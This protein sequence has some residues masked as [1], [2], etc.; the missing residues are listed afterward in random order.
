MLDTLRAS[1][2]NASTM[3]FAYALARNGIYFERAIAPGTWTATSHAALF[4]GKKVTDI[5]EASEDF[6]TRG[7]YKIDPWMVKTKFLPADSNTL[8][9]RLSSR[10]E[11]SLFSNNPFV[12][13]FTNMGIGFNVV[14]DIWLHTNVKYNKKLTEKFSFV[15]NSGSSGRMAMYKASKFIASFMPRP[16]LDRVYMKLRLKLDEQVDRAD[17]THRLDRGI[18][19]TNKLL[20][21]YLSKYP[22]A[23]H[24]IFIN[25][26]EP[27]ENYPIGKNNINQDKWLYLSGILELDEKI[28]KKLHNGYV[29]RLR[30]LD[31][32]LR[33]SFAILKRL[34]F[35]EDAKVIITSDHGQSFGEH[36]QL[37]HAVFPYEEIAHVPFAIIDYSNGKPIASN[38]TIEEPANII[39]LYK[40]LVNNCSEDSIA[41]SMPT[42]TEHTSIAEGWDERLLL[43]LKDRSTIAR[44]IY[45]AKK[46]YNT[47][48]VAVYKGNYKLIHFFGGKKDLLFDIA[49]DANETENII[50]KNRDIASSMLNYYFGLK[51]KPNK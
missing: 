16:L 19:D 38:K 44:K 24:F 30:Y 48:A 10:Y 17:G 23:S 8:A 45:A 34:G 31:K 13:S 1:D 29:M 3:P 49:K 42:I 32:K 18:S 46:Y 22:Y 14:Q 40:Y 4:A 50:G 12:T 41:S 39:S 28:K 37:F 51:S 47:K 5:K 7:T 6:F 43:M 20:N 15:L 26:I 2:F 33:E 36:G 21:A 25:L 35:L 9:K 11:T 27:H